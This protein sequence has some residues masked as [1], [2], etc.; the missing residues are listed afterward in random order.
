M[1]RSVCK[2]CITCAHLCSK[3]QCCCAWLSSAV[4]SQLTLPTYLTCYILL[5]VATAARSSVLPMPYAMSHTGALV[6]LAT[7]LLVALCNDFTSML[8]VNNA[9]ETGLDS[10]ESL[11]AWAGGP[12]W[13]V[14]VKGRGW[15]GLPRC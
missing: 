2:P 12:K 8:M 14:R 11:A 10:Y 4:V 15:V 3:P 6:G 5:A 1:M 9:Y 13:K 7:M